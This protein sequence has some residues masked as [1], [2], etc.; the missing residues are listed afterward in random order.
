M[1]FP[2]RRSDPSFVEPDREKAR[3]AHDA[4]LALQPQGAEHATCDLCP[5][6]TNKEVA[7]VAGEDRT[8]TEAEHLAL[9]AD[10]VKRETAQLTEAKSDLETKLSEKAARVDVLEAEKSNLETEKSALQKEFDDY[11]ASVERALE[12][13][14]AK[15][16]R[17][18]QIKAANDK[19]PDAYFT[20]ERVQAW[21]EMD[22]TA[23]AIVLDG[24][25]ALAGATKETAAFAG[26]ITPTSADKDDKPSVGRIFAA[27]RGVAQN[28]N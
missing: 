4:L 14:T 11:K 27:R 10:A 2:H 24:L 5:E 13:E 15:K 28:E 3:I 18:G 19:L 25:T 6:I 9:S 21:A 23:F 7:K 8:Y 26:G 22:E 20:D 16:D 12:I 17:V 1:R